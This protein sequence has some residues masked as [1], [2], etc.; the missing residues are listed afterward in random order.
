MKVRGSEAAASHESYQ[1]RDDGVNKEEV[2]FDAPTPTKGGG[3]GGSVD[4]VDDGGGNNV[5]G[6]LV[7]KATAK[8]TPASTIK[9]NENT[10]VGET[11]QS[12]QASTMNAASQ[13]PAEPSKS[14]AVPGLISRYMNNV[15]FNYSSG[16]N[17]STESDDGQQFSTDNEIE[18]EQQ[19]AKP[20]APKQK[21]PANT[22]TPSNEESEE[23]TP[24]TSQIQATVDKNQ[25]ATQRKQTQYI[26]SEY[27]KNIREAIKPP[28]IPLVNTLNKYNRRFSASL[29]L[30]RK[31]IKRKL[32]GKTYSGMAFYETIISKSSVLPDCVSIGSENLMEAIREPNC[33]IVD[34]VNDHSPEGMQPLTRE[35]CIEDISKLVNRINEINM[36]VVLAKSPV[37]INTSI[38]TRTLRAHFGRGIALHPTQTK[39]YNAD[40]DGDPAFLRF[41]DKQVD[42]Y[43][44][45]MTR[46]V[47]IEGNPTVD[48][49][50]FPI[51]AID[52]GKEKD[53][54]L[55][56][57]ERN[58]AWN[59]SVAEAI[60]PYYIK[61]C[62][63]MDNPS[64]VA[65]LTAIDK[66]AGKLAKTDSEYTRE[67]LNA[68]IFKDLYDFSID[69]RGWSLKLQFGD[70]IDTYTEVN[71]D[72][73]NP[74]I[75]PIIRLYED[76]AAGVSAPNFQ[77]FAEF[78]NRQ[79][80]EY[81][82]KNI[83]FRLLADFAK[84]INRTD[85]INVGDKVAVPLTKNGEPV[86]NEDGKQAAK[87]VT[88][89]DIYK[90]TCTAA[91]SKLIS[92]RLKMGSH[93][94]AVST[95]VKT[96]VLMECPVPVFSNNEREAA[97]QFSDWMKQFQRVY[98][99]HMRMLNISQ[100]GFRAGMK[101]L[102]EGHLQYDGFDR[103]SDKQF[104]K[105]FAEVYGD[106]SV[107][108]IFGNCLV[109]N[110]T[111]ENNMLKKGE[112]NR[113]SAILSLYGKMTINEFI[114]HNRLDF[115]SESVSDDDNPKETIDIPKMEAINRRFNKG[116]IRSMDVLMCLAD[117]RSKEFG[118]Y[119]K[120]FI[121]ATDTHYDIFK[122]IY[123]S[124][125]EDKYDKYIDDMLD[126]IHL[127]SP[128]LF[129][130]F[131]MSSTNTFVN[132]K[133][134]KKLLA[135]ESADEIRSIFTSMMVEYRLAYPAQILRELN[136]LSKSEYTE[137]V[138]ER[139]DHLNAVYESEMNTISSSS[140]AWKAILAEEVNGNKIFKLLLENNGEYIPNKKRWIGEY[141]KGM[142]SHF[143]FNMYAEDFWKSTDASKQ[144]SLVNFL[145]SSADYET[146]MNVLCDIVRVHS[147]IKAIDP[148]Q[149]IGM[150]AHDPDPLTMGSRFAMDQN[151]R[152]SIDD[153][154]SSIKRISAY[155]TQTP[156]AIQKELGKLD[157]HIKEIGKA[158]F[159]KELYRFATVPGEHVYVDT[160]FAA[161]AIASVYN[162]TYDDSE[163]IKQQSLVN[164]FFELVS[165]QRC[166]GFFT[167]LQQTDN[168]VV[169]VVGFDQ[170]SEFDIVRILGDP[171]IEL[172]GYDEFGRPCVYSRESLCGGSSID[173]VIKY[174]KKHPRI[175]MACRHHFGG[176]N[177]DVDGTATLK[178]VNNPINRTITDRVFALLNDRPRFLSIAALLT[179]TQKMP[180]RAVS[181]LVNDNI[182][183]LC[184]FVAIQAR[185]CT[186]PQEIIDAI[187]SDLG[188]TVDKLMSVRM[189]D[190]FDENDKRDLDY[191][192]V[193][194]TYL[195]VITE[196]VDCVCL[197]QDNGLRISNE[198]D[199]NTHHHVYGIDKSSMRAYFDA[200]Q[201]LT[202]ARTSKMIS[203]E[204]GETKKNLV[205]KEYV[206]NRPDKWMTVTRDMSHQALT[207]LGNELGGRNLIAELDKKDDG[208]IV[209]KVPDGW[210]PEDLSLEHT[211][212]KQ[213]GSI[214]K[215]LEI[216]RENGAEKFNAKAKKYGDDGTNSI[217]KFMKYATKKV[218][219]AYDK[220][221]SWSV[222]NG[223]DLRKAIIGAETKDQA[224]ELLASA[225]IEAD[226]RLG[227]V[228]T[229]TVFKP[230][231][232]YNRADLMIAEV[233]GQLYIRT[234]EQL[235]AA[236]RNRISDDAIL[237]SDA[238]AVL[239]ELTELE[240]VIGTPSD[241][242]MVSQ[243]S[244]INDTLVDVRVHSGM[245][246]ERIDRAL[247]PRSS[248]VE[249]N[250]GL[251]SKIFSRLNQ[252]TKK[253]FIQPSREY[254]NDLSAK[255][256]QKLSRDDFS[257]YVSMK[258][259]GFPY[260]YLG[261]DDKY[262][263]N[264]NGSRDYLY[265]YIGRPHDEGFEFI[266]GPQSLVYFDVLD[267]NNLELC[268]RYGMT[269]LFT[270]FN[271]VPQK[272]LGDL[273]LLEDGM[274]ILPFFDMELNG[275]VSEPIAPAPSVYHA[276]ADNM[277]TA[278]E[279][280][281][282]EIK[283]GDSSGHATSEFLD[284]I[285]VFFSDVK[286]LEVARLFPNVLNTYWH[287]PSATLQLELA[288]TAEVIREILNSPID[289]G[290]GTAPEGATVID[291]GV[292]P[293]DVE[294]H[295]RECE[296]FRLRLAKYAERLERQG[297]G[298][299][300]KDYKETHSMLQCE[301]D[302]D[303]IVGFVKIRIN[304]NDYVF[305]PVIPFHMEESGSAPMK[306]KMNGEMVID[307]E[308]RTY[309]YP[310]VYTGDLA[311][312]YIKYFESIGASN[313]IIIDGG[314]PIRSRT[315]A[316]GI[317]VDI[318][319][320]SATVASRLFPDNKRLHTIVSML[321]IPR[322]DFSFSYNLG[323]CTDAFPG[324]KGIAEAL[325]S[326][327][328]TRTDWADIMETIPD[329]KF[330][331]DPEIDSVIRWLVKK[332]LDFGTVNPSIFLAT[333]TSEDDPKDN[334][335]IPLF[336]EFEAFLDTGY[337][338]QNALMKFMHAMQPTLVP[339]SIDDDASN[340]LFKPVGQGRTDEYYGVL[341]MM[342]PCY[343]EYSESGTTIGDKS[344]PAN[345]YI[346]P[347]FMGEEFS[348]IKRVNFNAS[349]NGIDDLNVASQL[350]KYS[351]AQVMGFAR[352]GMSHVPSFG[353][354]E[355]TP[356]TMLK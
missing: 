159:E 116:E 49:D 65:L 285:K 351:L 201:T 325:R 209:V 36:D 314:N 180:G 8:T 50:F 182:K 73:V 315:L 356:D 128:K 21:Q 210:V 246:Y 220:E 261:E 188:I 162:K 51:D 164:A 42:K 306:F 339:E 217:I 96:R 133:Y 100:V 152:G 301:C 172:N 254:I 286:Q 224:V 274:F 132:S 329:L 156:E 244:I 76:V 276:T 259:I 226:K 221:S 71:T 320:A 241:P 208:M 264:K 155:K 245:K 271:C 205:L 5:V 253:E 260:D 141:E 270:D 131:D 72:N 26:E 144:Y 178:V 206:R 175:A 170:L 35:E 101:I 199:I 55:A 184:D 344:I 326:N 16:G 86:L 142:N 307:H 33:T 158:N 223:I 262:H 340:C 34:M 268:K 113:D 213:T 58:F 161:D 169:N 154:K 74:E 85:L 146:K 112:E 106:Y 137:A 75:I 230:S 298:V 193:Y 1:T 62:Q 346:G 99:K 234:L 130:F 125:Q 348:G 267:P 171:D 129:D 97:K 303:D 297:Q 200:I 9:E 279:D 282:Y 123:K 87:Y 204:G 66:E 31:Q 103:F 247:N 56:M 15:G 232:Y 316:N 195:K 84:A 310:W 119:Q 215:F 219:K 143:K 252:D 139:I 203:V 13:G 352:G 83:P 95:H 135:V 190:S 150:L 218:L 3:G 222:E 333:R 258:G 14:T 185:D 67:R 338:F 121:E 7:D 102:R 40:F 82:N 29:D 328:L 134:G 318:M 283:P 111:T 347:S 281:T 6:D 68:L 343:G 30:V 207:K 275:S 334:K 157:K 23:V 257:V 238:N 153:L 19:T 233:D 349:K 124:Y 330:H 38:Q 110:A 115:L 92:G 336:T 327:S 10:R 269:A 228:D 300:D 54:L 91:T 288:D 251:V 48:P 120:N 192:T 109:R 324:N 299:N 28:E 94:M 236:F 250:Y 225:L 272:Y 249:R 41:D 70:V 136:E 231:D 165:L 107:G 296:R 43:G 163:K 294:A 61:L 280:K 335:A 12:S 350:D 273:V 309:Q 189:N 59:E 263:M 278:V 255:M 52:K 127:M 198:L 138:G 211:P 167:H 186:T 191:Q 69:R 122:R 304:A 248:S 44:R 90:I 311:G 256:M 292:L 345:V 179:F 242:M 79:Y 302:F 312:Q 118:D 177:N 57:K 295:K 37:N 166:G 104:A 47:D 319:Y 114:I 147:G 196:I 4:T 293:N 17:A 342:V 354:M 105:A 18:N 174:I 176:V 235:S 77:D 98:N 183:A 140:M 145:K 227:Y 93:Q 88:M 64:W 45:A 284:R 243:E 321:M 313:K 317:P 277:V 24:Q 332:C 80:G 214:A 202:G 11:A 173:D 149:M 308:T 331:N 237:S 239:N 240:N 60:A 25:E 291:V 46:L 108:R 265:D 151:F 290:D 266:P 168:A 39:G 305:A 229:K 27:R 160:I 322:L 187:E 337:N 63:N 212:R 22:A 2:K 20:V 197:V 32:R 81:A 53:V 148:T 194:A 353:S 126:A 117:R 181:T 78:F 216:K 323:E 289:L 355:V 341:Q 89:Y 287:N